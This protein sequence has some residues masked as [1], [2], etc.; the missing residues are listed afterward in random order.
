MVFALTRI[1]ICC[2][3]VSTSLLNF[4]Q[5]TSAPAP[6]AAQ[7]NP[8]CGEE[9]QAEKEDQHTS[10]KKDRRRIEAEEEEKRRSEKEERKRIQAEKEEKCRAQRKERK[11]CL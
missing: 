1:L 9:A 3:F 2:R 4:S 7:G 10:K 6:S 11:G 8:L 5:P